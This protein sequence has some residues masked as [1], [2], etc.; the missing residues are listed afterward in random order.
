MQGHYTRTPISEGGIWLDISV[1][2]ARPHDQV[3]L[4]LE[5]RLGVVAHDCQLLE[6]GITN[7]RDDSEF[8]I[9]GDVVGCIRGMGMR[10][11]LEA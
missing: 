10:C 8:T 5:G 3:E 2:Q 1:P 6:W 11:V 7:E 9:G 4:R